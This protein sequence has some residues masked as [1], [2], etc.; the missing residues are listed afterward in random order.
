MTQSSPR[1]E[2]PANANAD[3]AQT[4]FLGLAV[5]TAMPFAVGVVTATLLLGGV[6]QAA[7]MKGNENAK[8]FLFIMIWVG[9]S[10][11]LMVLRAV[12]GLLCP[13]KNPAI[14]PG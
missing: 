11:D 7:S 3:E 9:S 1:V 12:P 13:V 8:Y 10:L 5:M 14:Q 2:L 4:V 6:V